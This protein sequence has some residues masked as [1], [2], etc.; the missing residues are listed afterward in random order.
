LRGEG[1]A[2]QERKVVQS[3]AAF[4]HRDRKV[5]GLAFMLLQRGG[6]ED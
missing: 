6:I 5:I 4:P 3:E 2:V 1:A